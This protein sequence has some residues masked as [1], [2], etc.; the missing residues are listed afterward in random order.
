MK[1]AVAAEEGHPPPAKIKICFSSGALELIV[2]SLL[3]SVLHLASI[4]T[5]A[6]NTF[7][8]LV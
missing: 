2:I 5:T 6:T 8:L 1:I 4:I 7:M 3:F